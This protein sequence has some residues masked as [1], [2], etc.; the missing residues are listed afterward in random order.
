M[1][2]VFTNPSVALFGDLLML[3]ELPYGRRQISF[4]V[5]EVEVVET[6]KMPIIK[7]V[8]QELN[9]KLETPISS[10]SLR[11]LSENSRKI[12][13]IVPDNTRAFPSREIMPNLIKYIEEANPQAEIRIL[14]ATGLHV[15]VSKQELGEMLGKEIVEN[16]EVV[17]H[18][19]MDENQVL[20][21]EKRTSYGTPIHVNREVMR[22]DLVIG[23]GLIEPHFFAGYSG[24]RKILLPGV[25]GRDAV[26]NNHGFRMIG[27]RNS[28]AGILDGNPIHEDMIE[29]ME[30][31]RLDFIVNVTLNKEKK[32][33]GIFAGDPVKAHLEGVRFLD[34]YVKSYFT[35]EADLVLTTNGGYPLDRDLY[36][37]VKGMDTAASVVKNGGVIV[38][39]SECRD[40]LGGHE[41]FLRLVQGAESPEEI[42]ER[43]KKEEPIYD[44]WE[45]QVLARVLKKASVILVSE[46]ISD[47]VAEGLLLKRARDLEEALEMAYEILGKKDVKIAAIPEG[48]Y[49]IPSRKKT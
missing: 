34:N 42:L 7:L 20:K 4:E 45:A 38:I 10:P 40:G 19:A 25:A 6:R 32:I 11:K 39:A 27:H 24:G 23:A 31:T 30:K 18:D 15:E 28:R 35:E 13:L 17:N 12:L 43:I 36:Q 22:S 37:A 46:Y 33:S 3:I 49:V 8:D 5:D 47:E 26:F 44:Q 14:V 9:G 29:F 2:K 21:L 1:R 41:E 48:P 16:Y